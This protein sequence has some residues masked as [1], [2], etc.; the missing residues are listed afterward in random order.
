[1]WSHTA[2]PPALPRGISLRVRAAQ[3]YTRAVSEKAV[4]RRLAALLSADV[5]GYSR[6]MAAD[7]VAT[8]RAVTACREQLSDLVRGHEGRVV[9]A[10]G[11]N[12]LAEFPAAS[13][14]AECAVA[15][16]RAMAERNAPLAEAQRMLLRIGL[17]LGEVLVE[18]ERLYGDGV[19]VAAR[20]EALAP[21]GGLACSQ[22][23]RDELRG[24]VE[25]RLEDA[26]ERELKNIARPV[27]VF[28]AAV[29]PAPDARP[30]LPGARPSIVVLPF[31]NMSRDPEQEYFADGMSEELIT[32]LSKLSGLLVI[33]RTSAFSY[34]GR[35]VRVD[36]IARELRVRYVLE[37]SVRHAG[38]R[39]RV[40]A[41]L[42]DA[43]GGH[44]LWAERY[45]RGLE[46]VFAV[47]DE[48]TAEIV[49]ALRVEL[50]QEA[51]QGSVPTRSVEAYDLYLRGTE[52]L[53]RVDRDS[54][55][56]AREFFER[57]LELDP[58]FALALGELARSWALE[59]GLHSPPDGKSALAR[60]EGLVRQA[61]A[62]DSSQARLHACLSYICWFSGKVE[63][64]LAA[65]QRAVALAPGEAVAQTWLGWSLLEAGRLEEAIEPMELAVRLDPRSA[66]VH[67]GVAALYARLGRLEEA[68][69]ATLQ[70]Q[71]LTPAFG[72]AY[73]I[74]TQVL[75]Q[76]GREADARAAASEVMRLQP[77]FTIESMLRRVPGAQWYDTEA[78]RRAGL[79]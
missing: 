41:Q 35:S 4:E 9:D 34:K 37:G 14:A 72:P 3:P 54:V 55:R 74:A 18:G 39:V 32:A 60:A 63:E 6:L 71:Q 29:A 44:H 15:I 76:L 17:H 73:L 10:P 28:L 30:S 49:N 77:D 48:L 5:V 8:L 70:V 23:L 79:P 67:N 57:A 36:E 31:A 27:R 40:T 33:A 53:W 62:L 61:L 25:L 1:M 19:N 47:Q 13:R 50:G 2:L 12:L 75:M 42:I 68:L 22:A 69:A 59:Y 78:L 26:G 46:D 38:G 20:L 66:S 65:A 52:L 45:D 21:P 64:G 58:R 11:D 24:R 56:R 43:Q 16:Q 51:R 7:E